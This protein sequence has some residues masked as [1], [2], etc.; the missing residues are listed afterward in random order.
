MEK[1]TKTELR[2][3]NKMPILPKDLFPLKIT[4]MTNNVYHIPI[5]KTF[6]GRRKDGDGSIYPIEATGER[7]YQFR[8][9]EVKIEQR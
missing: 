5:G 6:Y 1:L 4:I 8:E 3:E 2:E 7:I 9:C